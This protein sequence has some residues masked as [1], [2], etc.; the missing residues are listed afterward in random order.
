MLSI[1][2]ISFPFLALRCLHHCCCWYCWYRSY[3]SFPFT[4]FSSFLL[5]IYTFIEDGCE[6][7]MTR[8]CALFFSKWKYFIGADH[9]N[10]IQI[11]LPHYMRKIYKHFIH[12]LTCTCRLKFFCTI[13]Y[14]WFQLFYMLFCFVLFCIS[15][16]SFKTYKQQWIRGF[17]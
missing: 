7:N 14:D 1:L 8:E 12:S 4:S 5:S 3:F 15:F 10:S 16:N 2:R 6:L 17:N 9:R 13:E 11:R